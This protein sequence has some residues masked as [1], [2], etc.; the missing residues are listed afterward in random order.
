[1]NPSDSSWFA[2][3]LEILKTNGQTDT[4][5][6]AIGDGMNAS[7][8]ALIG[9]S[10]VI[11]LPATATNFKIPYYVIQGRRD[12][13]APTPL[14][15]AYFDKVS[16]PKKQL[17]VI[18]NAGH[19]ALST[20]QKISSQRSTRC[21]NRTNKV[22]STTDRRSTVIGEPSAMKAERGVALRV[23]TNCSP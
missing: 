13:F 7:G 11:D 3:M 1:M 12:L 22:Q 21:Y 14:A 4:T 17:V 8:S 6:K 2:N 19:F 20:H 15:K 16:A 18:E 10:V 9:T 5:L 23:W